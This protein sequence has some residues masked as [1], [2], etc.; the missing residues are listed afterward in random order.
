M[1]KNTFRFTIDSVL[2][3]ESQAQEIQGSGEFQSSFA[4]DPDETLES[5]FSFLTWS[6][7]DSLNKKP[8]GMLAPVKAYSLT[9]TTVG[10]PMWIIPNPRPEGSS[11]ENFVYDSAG[12]VYTLTT[13]GV[14][15][16]TGLGDL[17][18]A[19]SA[20]G[21]G[22]AYYDNYIYFARSTNIAR[23]GP[24]DGTRA[25]TD[26]YW[27]TTLGKAALTDTNYPTGQYSSTRS[28]NH[29]MKR[30]NDGKLYFA[31][32]VGNQGVLHYISTRKTTV[33]GDTDNGSTYNAL[34]FPY[35]YWPTA[36]ESYGSQLVVGLFDGANAVS[37]QTS[38]GSRAKI[39]F[40]DTTSPT[41]N[42]LIDF[43][44]P[45]KYISKIVNVNGNLYFFSGDGV[46]DFG[47]RL[48]QY[49]GGNA[50]KE[51][52]R[53]NTVPL[54]DPG[55]V[56]DDLT[57]I[58]FAGKYKP[59]TELNNTEVSFDGR[60]CVQAIGSRIGAPFGLF[61]VLGAVDS[62]AT[63]VTSVLFDKERLWA[64]Y[65]SF[66]GSN[67]GGISTKG[68]L[69]TTDDTRAQK[70]YFRS[71]TF[72]VGEPFKV[73]KIRIPLAQSLENV[74]GNSTT[75]EIVPYVWVDSGAAIHTLTTVNA[76]NFPNTSTR[77]SVTIR[78]DSLTGETD[79]F[80]EL[81]W[82]T[83]EP[84]TVKLPVVIEGEYLDT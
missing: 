29:V 75:K 60:A 34:D 41:Y 73:T 38:A 15:S 12:S 52:V 33:E 39:A 10:A 49:I 18:D 83:D 24:L 81:E 26:S 3:G 71:Q 36:I 47:L 40:W 66:S 74:T 11:L 37:T 23:Y 6:V 58:Y 5:S 13:A 61:T 48:T 51:I 4:I 42:Q 77:R 1:A 43:E 7:N 54:P 80:I 8:S 45:D 59:A 79:F 20:E 56:S 17:N 76:T 19:G 16:V 46:Q 31:D 50:F 65:F 35:G 64:G 25:F 84:L 72:H 69:T 82:D 27:V 32:V 28:A 22:A 62:T 78:P 57:R 9:E 55:A 30:H 67:Y 44:F 70:H 68:G 2:G 21:N 63:A 53:F 14:A